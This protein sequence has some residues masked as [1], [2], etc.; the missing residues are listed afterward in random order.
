[1]SDALEQEFHQAMLEICRVAKTEI[2]YNP[3]RFVQMIADHGGLGAA[4]QLLHASTVSEG[5]T[6]LWEAKRLDLTVE[7]HVLDPRFAPLFT[8]AEL[9]IAQRRLDEYGYR[10]D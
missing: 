6:K 10:R 5:F 9:R 1:M 4:R 8:D 7:K 3:S 2:R